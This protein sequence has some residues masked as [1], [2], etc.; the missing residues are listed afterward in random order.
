MKVEEDERTVSDQLG[1][2]VSEA[3]SL[4]TEREGVMTVKKGI[5]RSLRELNAKMKH[6]AGEVREKETE[7]NCL[8]TTRDNC[9]ALWV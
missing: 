6:I 4:H 7:K 9:I 2:A 8:K 3:S 5:D 1:E